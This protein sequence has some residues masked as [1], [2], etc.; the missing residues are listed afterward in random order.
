MTPRA[1]Y[2]DIDPYAC[3]VLAKQITAGKSMEIVDCST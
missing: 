3:R 1:Y 2:N